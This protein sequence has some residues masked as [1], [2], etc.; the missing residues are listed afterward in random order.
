MF[1][2]CQQCAK[3]ESLQIRVRDHLPT[4]A[5]CLNEFHQI[6]VNCLVD[7]WMLSGFPE[8]QDSMDQQ[9]EAI[10]SEMCLYLDANDERDQ[11]G[12]NFISVHHLIS[13]T[14]S[15]IDP[16]AHVSCARAM[17]PPTPR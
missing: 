4:V 7:L 16:L 3:A 12:Y 14:T 10:Y 6:S 1:R 5:V 9:M 2:R 8:L 17:T 11:S 15:G 13:I